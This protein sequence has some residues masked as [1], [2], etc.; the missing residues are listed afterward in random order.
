MRRELAVADADM[1]DGDYATPASSGSSSSPSRSEG[2]SQR[3]RFNV[4][5]L[6]VQA[7][8]GCP[9]IQ[10]YPNIQLFQT[11]DISTFPN[12]HVVH[13][14]SRWRQRLQEP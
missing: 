5:T 11:A 10:T 13:S 9:D 8:P 7:R 2:A 12:V 6:Y 1:S 3:P 14:K 4:G